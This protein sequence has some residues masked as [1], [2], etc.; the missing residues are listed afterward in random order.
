ML[1]FQIGT[2]EDIYL[3]FYCY[4]KEKTNDSE[5][6]RLH[7]KVAD[8]NGLAKLCGLSIAQKRNPTAA[9]FR[10]MTSNLFLFAG[11]EKITLAAIIALRLWDE[12]VNKVYGF[13][14]PQQID[15]LARQIIEE[16]KLDHF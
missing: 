4:Y 6:R 12:R 1:P 13:T 2:L 16:S 3:R 11:L 9:D 15:M 10:V 7:Q 5:C 8:S 14:S